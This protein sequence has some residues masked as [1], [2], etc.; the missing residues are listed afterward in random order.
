MIGH[1]WQAG[2]SVT[3]VVMRVDAVLFA[4]PDEGV[5][6]CSFPAAVGGAEEEPVLLA[7]GCGPNHIFGEVIINLNDS[8]FDVDAKLWP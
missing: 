1:V 7:D 8:I 2:E 4:V 5:N 6:E 3:D